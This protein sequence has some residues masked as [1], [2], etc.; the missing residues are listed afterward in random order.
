MPLNVN[1][2]IFSLEPIKDMTK[3]LKAPQI[4]ILHIVHHPNQTH[5]HTRTHAH[6]DIQTNNF[7]K[8][9]LNN[10]NIKTS[11]RKNNNTPTTQPSPNI[12]NYLHTFSQN[13]FI[14]LVKHKLL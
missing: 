5:T 4:I 13:N 7:F 8:T 1:K 3:N 14:H 2:D 6:I 9:L 11:I 12:N 10:F